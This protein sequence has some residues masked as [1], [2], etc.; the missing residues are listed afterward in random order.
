VVKV[1]PVA[2]SGHLSMMGGET[3]TWTSL[4]QLL[5]LMKIA[6]VVWKKVMIMDKMRVLE[7]TT[8][9]VIELG[10]S[11]WTLVRHR[12]TLSDLLPIIQSFMYTLRCPITVHRPFRQLCQQSN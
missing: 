1:V 3:D 7:C 11:D 10:P 12:G 2:R 8:E 9:I 4:N 6:S 5:E